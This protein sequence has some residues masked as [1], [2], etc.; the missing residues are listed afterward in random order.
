MPAT[1]ARDVAERLQARLKAP[2]LEEENK[3]WLQERIDTQHH[4]AMVQER[5]P[6]T[7]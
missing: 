1:T 5:V 3:K 2:E 7:V 4:L 6:K